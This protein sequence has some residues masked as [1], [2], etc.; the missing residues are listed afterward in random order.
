MDG[1]KNET[2]H[3]SNINIKPFGSSMVYQLTTDHGKFSFWSKK[4]DG[5]PSKAFEQWEKFGYKIGD[6]VDIAYSEKQSDKVNPHTGK[7]YAPNKNVA[8]FIT[9][10]EN[11]PSVKPTPTSQSTETP[12]KTSSA[13]PDAKL[14]EIREMLYSLGQRMNV[15][16][17]RLGITNTEDI[18]IEDVPFN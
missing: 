17:E 6:T 2:I 1:V 12:E 9:V 3:I 4:Q 16:E 8:Y 11:T 10:D 5:T 13:I 18:R 7:P 14:T 15:V